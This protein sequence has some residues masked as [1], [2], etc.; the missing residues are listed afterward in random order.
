MPFQY[1]QQH[2]IE[3]E[4]DGLTILR[5]VI[6]ATLLADLRRETDKAC[7]IA[8]RQHGPQAQRLQPVYEYEKLKS[9]M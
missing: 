4:R 6:P 5:G 9:R 3:Y 8:R 2:R 7:E 1:T